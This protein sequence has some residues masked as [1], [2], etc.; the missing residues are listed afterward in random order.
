MG[1]MTRGEFILLS[2][3]ISNAILAVPK[4][5]DLVNENTSFEYNVDENGNLEVTG[6]IKSSILSKCYLVE[7]K[8]EKGNLRL[9]I[10]NKDGVDILTDEFVTSV[11]EVEGCIISVDDDVY[12]VH[13]MSE[14]YGEEDG[15]LLSPDDVREI[16]VIIAKDFKWHE[17]KVLSYTY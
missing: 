6:Q 8:D 16:L 1:K 11:H 14:Y 12:S 15:R 3:A 2:Y 5:V 7:R 4:I 10:I 13:K 9:S 17:Y